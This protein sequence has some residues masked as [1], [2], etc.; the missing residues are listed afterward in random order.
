MVH[1]DSWTTSVP[2]EFLQA[3]L[4]QTGPLGIRL[5]H[6]AGKQSPFH[7]ASGQ[8]ANLGIIFCSAV[9]PW[10]RVLDSCSSLE[11]ALFTRRSLVRDQIGRSWSLAG[12]IRS[13]FFRLAT[14]FTR[15]YP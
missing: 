3:R 8:F 11:L 4:D 7:A 6:R 14:E 15:A 5:S 1:S 12:T 9:L 10:F 13:R 2:A